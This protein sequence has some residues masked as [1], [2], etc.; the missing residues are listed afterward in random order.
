MS[1][2]NTSVQLL[3]LWKI[4]FFVYLKFEMPP[5]GT[6]KMRWEKWMS[7][8]LWKMGILL[9]QRRQEERVLISLRRK[10][11]YTGRNIT[12]SRPQGNRAAESLKE[13][14]TTGGIKSAWIQTDPPLSPHKHTMDKCFLKSDSCFMVVWDCP[15][16][17]HLLIIKI[18]LLEWD[19]NSSCSCFK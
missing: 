16:Q 3:S 17:L 12:I 9:E 5:F 6:W 8:C 18:C 14:M 7:F 13:L 1:Q 19:F 2:V 10:S 11:V 4:G 15:A